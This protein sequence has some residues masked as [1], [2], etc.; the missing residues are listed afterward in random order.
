[1]RQEERRSLRR[2][3]RR[4]DKFVVESA[5]TVSSYVHTHTHVHSE[6][7]MALLLAWQQGPMI[8]QSKADSLH[9]LHAGL[10]QFTVKWP[11]EGGIPAQMGSLAKRPYSS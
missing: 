1:M 3:R 10:H 9:S 4:K 11:G 2:K 5:G 8:H 6:P 7:S